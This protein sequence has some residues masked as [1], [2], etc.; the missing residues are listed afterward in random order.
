MLYSLDGSEPA[1]TY[2]NGVAINST[3]AVRA[4]VVRTGYKPSR[5]Q[6]K[7]FIFLDD[8][9]ANANMSATIKNNAAY[10][11]RLRPGLLALPTISLC[12]PGQ[13]EY[14][15]QPGSVE[16]IWPD[17]ANGVQVNCGVARFGNAWTKFAKRSIRVKCRADYGESKFSTPLFNGFDRGVLA[18]TSFDEISSPSLRLAWP[19]RADG[20]G[21]SLE[22]HRCPTATNSTAEAQAIVADGRHWR[23]SS[24]YHGSPG[25]VEPFEKAVRISE[26]LGAYGRRGRLG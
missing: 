26:I 10:A 18:K 7:T 12:V 6:T 13:P 8:V 14:W 5:S 1:L 16:V 24:L 11:P 23:S 2:A 3:K 19:E 21:S 22:L 4:K 9:I 20:K 17:G 25:R 15:E